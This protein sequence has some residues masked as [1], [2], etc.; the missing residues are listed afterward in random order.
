MRAGSAALLALALSACSTT[1]ASPPRSAV[2]TAPPAASATSSPATAPASPR[3][4]RYERAVLADRP[5]GL[6]T[7]TDVAGLRA[8]DAVVDAS[9]AAA[10][11]SLVEGT[12]RATTGPGGETAARFVGTGRIVTPVGTLL[13]PGRPFTIELYFRADDCTRHWTQ[14]AGTAT[15]TRTGR[16]GVNVLH[17]PRS[18]STPC[19]L[20]VEFWRNDRYVGGCGPSAVARVGAWLHFAVAYDGR[21]AR[22]YVGGALIGTS[23]VPDFG[24]GAT[25][26]FGIGGAGEGYA[27]TLDSGSLAD[28]AVYSRALAAPVLRRHAAAMSP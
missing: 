4:Q 23:V 28:V 21:V 22:C 10:D 3:Q 13:R 1:S 7:L 24:F 2:T 12:V 25:V 14:V 15:Y 16:Q 11:G 5:S 19:H 27:G 8:G 6:W 18:S 20:A 9:A 17:Y 26:P